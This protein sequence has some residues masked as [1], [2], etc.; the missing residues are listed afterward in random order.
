MYVLYVYKI[1]QYTKYN[2]LCMPEVKGFLNTT[3]SS[4]GYRL[5]RVGK[6]ERFIENSE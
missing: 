1:I 6:K 5:K 3:S 2:Q 4:I